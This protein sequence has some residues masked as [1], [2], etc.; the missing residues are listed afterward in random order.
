MTVEMAQ[1][2]GLVAA[3]SGFLKMVRGVEEGLVGEFEPAFRRG[4]LIKYE[5]TT[6]ISLPRT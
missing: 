1:K 6:R 2:P 4:G 5:H 3:F